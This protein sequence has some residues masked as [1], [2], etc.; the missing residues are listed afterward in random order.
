ME[1]YSVE[2]KAPD[3]WLLSGELTFATVAAIARQ[4][5][6]LP[7]GARVTLDLRGIS[8]ADSAGLALLV[9]WMRQARHS[10][11]QVHYANIPAQMLA[12]ARVS[13][14]DKILPLT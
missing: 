6:G 1:G 10:E 12:V 14:L 3:Y 7:R 8:R 13:G 11:A 5:L 9:D 4:G 2:I